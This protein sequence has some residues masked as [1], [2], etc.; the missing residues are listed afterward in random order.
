MNLISH[1][2]NIC[3]CKEL[4]IDSTSLL[5]CLP[6]AHDLYLFGAGERGQRFY[7]AIK[8]LAP[9]LNVAGFIDSQ[10]NGLYQDIEIHSPRILGRLA[11]DTTLILITSHKWAEIEEFIAPY[12]LRSLRTDIEYFRNVFEGGNRA[13]SGGQVTPQFTEEDMLSMGPSQSAVLKALNDPRQQ[14]LYRRL[15]SMRGWRYQTSAELSAEYSLPERQYLEWIAPQ[16][17]RT[18]IEGGMYDGRATYALIHACDDPT[19]Y[20]FEPLEGCYEKGI[21]YDYLSKHAHV[22][23]EIAGLW[24]SDGKRSFCD[25]E[26]CSFISDSTAAQGSRTIATR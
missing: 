26:Y 11:P 23:L 21:Y 17:V 8:T 4:V 16:H 25:N 5:R 2:N 9:Q 22:R 14:R 13:L 3:V 1:E 19:I 20:G 15:L 18:V 10:V 6:T 12:G 24:D 7:R